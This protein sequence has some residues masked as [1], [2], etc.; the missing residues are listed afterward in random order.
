MTVKTG[1]SLLIVMA[2]LA[3]T[4]CASQNSRILQGGNQV[5]LRSIQTRAFDTNDKAFVA[6]SIIATLQDLSFIID[7]A[8]LDLGTVSATK[9]GGYQIRM[10]VTVRP[11]SDTQM[12]VR[13]SA[14]FNLKPIEDPEPYQDFFNALGKSL[15][16]A[17][18]EVE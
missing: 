9:L 18:Q 5:E 13:A 14:Q 1:K 2:V 3:L 11:R 6:R 4:A 7:K 8:D 15:F 17:A 12:L 10:T 16:L